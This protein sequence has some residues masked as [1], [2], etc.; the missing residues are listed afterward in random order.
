[1][2]EQAIKSL[3]ELVG[4]IILPH[5]SK[6]MVNPALSV[7]KQLFQSMKDLVEAKPDDQS[8]LLDVVADNLQLAQA[9]NLIDEA[10][11]NEALGYIE[12]AK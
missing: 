12:Q 2:A 4:R 7:G 3:H 1:M 10:T 6:G 9:V 8:R 5:G 11:L